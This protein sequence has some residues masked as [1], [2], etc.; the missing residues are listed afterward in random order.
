M[1]K[2]HAPPTRADRSQALWLSVFT[3]MTTWRKGLRMNRKIAV[4]GAGA[5]ASSVGE[6]LTKTGY[7]VAIIDQ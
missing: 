6:D 5:I 1:K 2:K 7:D 4:L 3:G